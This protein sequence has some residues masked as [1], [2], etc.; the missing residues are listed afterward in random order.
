LPNRLNWQDLLMLVDHPLINGQLFYPR[1]NWAKPT[2][3]VKVLDAKL[4]CFHE[5]RHQTAG[6]VIY[7][8]GNGELASECAT[9]LGD[10]FLGMGVN[11]CFVEYRGYG[12]SSGAP[13]LGAMLA[14]GE[15]VLKALRVH[16]R[17]AVAF[18]RSL[19]CVYA[20]ELARRMPRLGG[21]ILESGSASVLEML[22]SAA[23]KIA[24]RAAQK[25]LEAELRTYF[26]HQ[27]ILRHYRGPL[28]VLHAASD[29]CQNATRL[30]SWGGGTDKRLVIFP[31]G[32]H[33]TI[34]LVNYR[35]YSHEVSCF[36]QRTGTIFGRRSG[37]VR[38][39]FRR[40]FLGNPIDRHGD[41]ALGNRFGAQTKTCL[42]PTR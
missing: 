36:L 31:E 3:V 4:A 18:G 42:P 8:H 19:G 30:H 14:D 32:N 5:Y 9:G 22:T 23:D 1:P 7:F 37:R 24:S 11:V 29:Q 33:N 38:S 25:N 35:E 27:A 13:A 34:L 10:V 2:L 40:L 26:D 41:D 20:I 39:F 16:P 15:C 17:R 28:L 12:A 6:W 21:L